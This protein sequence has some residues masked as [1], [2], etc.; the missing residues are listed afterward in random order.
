MRFATAGLV[1]AFA[2]SSIRATAPA[3]RT[4]SFEDRVKAQAAIERVYYSHQIGATKSF[5]EAMPKTTLDNKVRKVLAQTAALSVYWKTAVTDEMLQRELE[6]M[7]GATQ[8]PER[9]TEL[10]AALGNDPFMIKECLARATLVDRLTHN[11]YAFDSS[12]HADARRQAEELHRQLSSGELSP[13][14][15]HANRTVRHIAALP[16]HVGEVSEVKESRDAFAFNVILSESTTVARVASYVI[17]KT[18]WDA[19]WATAKLVLHDPSPATVATELGRLPVPASNGSS[20]CGVDDTWNN[21]TQSGVPE[22]RVDHTAVWTGTEMIVRGGRDNG[23]YLNSGGRYDPATDTWTTTSTVGAPYLG[24]AVWTGSLM[25]VWGSGTG[26]RYEPVADSWSPMSTSGAPPCGDLVWTERGLLVVCDTMGARYEPSTDTWTP[27]S[28]SGAPPAGKKIWTN[29]QLVVWNGEDNTGG[30]YNPLTDSWE[31]MATLGAPT[32]C[33]SNRIV[34][35]GKL[36]VVWCNGFHLGEVTNTGG[37]YDPGVDAWTPMSTTGGHR[38]RGG[39]TAVWTGSQMVVWG[40]FNRDGRARNTGARYDPGTDTWT[41]MSTE[42]VGG[43]SSHS[44]IWTEKLMVVWGGDSGPHNPGNEDNS[45]GRYNPEFDSWTPTSTVES[46]S[47]RKDHTAVWTGNVMVVWGGTDGDGDYQLATGGRFDPATGGWMPTSTEGVPAAR[48]H[49]TAVWTG[50]SMVVWGGGYDVYGEPRHFTNTGGRYDPA[51]DEWAPTS[52]VDAPS[53]RDQHTAVWTGSRMVVWGG[54]QFGTRFDTGGRYDP[55]TETWTPTSVTDAP[56]ARIAHTAIWTGN[57]MVVWGGFSVDGDLDS[58][59]RYDPDGDSWI[60]TSTDGAPTGRYGHTAVWTGSRMVI[61]GGGQTLVPNTFT[62]TGGRYD[63]ASDAWTPT[64]TATA[65][66]ARTEHTAVWSGNEMVVWGGYH[67]DF[68]GNAGVVNSG[69]RY[70]PATDAWTPTSATKAPAARSLHTAV[71]TG[72]QV[73]VWGGCDGA[74]RLEVGAGYALGAS[75]DNDGD[76]YTECQGD[77]HDDNATIYPGATQLC[78]GWNDDCSDPAWPAVPANE[79]DADRDG[80]RICHGDCDENDVA[81]F[82]GAPQVCDTKN[83]DC[84]DPTWPAVPATEIDADQDGFRGCDGDCND[85]DPSLHPGASDICD[86]IDNDCSGTVDDDGYP[87]DSDG[88]GVNHVCDNCP[89]DPN[90]TQIDTDGD[91]LGDACDNCSLLPNPAQMDFDSDGV[92]DGCDNCPSVQNAPQYDFDHDGEGDFCDVNDGL[93]FVYFFAKNFRQWMPES[94][95]TSWNS[96]RGSLA[97]LRATGQYTQAPGS[98]P[99]AARACGMSD[100]YVYD[101]DVPIPG[102]VAYNLVTG[103]A[104]GV[105]SSLG[106][107]SAGAPRHNANPCP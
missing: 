103:I 86:G 9:L 6:R 82:P 71:W 46:P 105:E 85:A 18:T 16:T 62:N 30:R 106:T 96:Y 45:G 70:D 59:G 41:G 40:G 79:A 49:H 39:S 98:N 32:D 57:R 60:P 89:T 58:G 94:G 90:P 66:S 36:M 74:V 100:L 23:D 53:A 24:A 22:A 27:I 11:F 64:F 78:D 25:L 29:K 4:L 92:G 44:A 61:W 33:S 26:A 95:Y 51:T 72:S 68:A 48:S 50:G 2:C 67:S 10:Y 99:L 107:N 43:R 3:Q 91:A 101:G 73:I 81:T 56:S 97:V 65:P 77:C 38:A 34:W 52:T 21:A 102:E 7:A 1:V 5:D 76:G 93:I 47:T 84:S 31:P 12:L 28:M 20:A 87:I 80:F 14:I 88:D 37:R 17:P 55:A 19:W 15:E 104:D 75:V 13:S 83:N 63:P 35:T 8:L 69:A 54:S 42:N